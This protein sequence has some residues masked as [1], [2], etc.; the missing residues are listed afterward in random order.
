MLEILFVVSLGVFT[1]VLTGLTP[2]IH[3]NTV[4]FGTMPFYFI[5][6]FTFINYVSFVVGLS[7]AHTFHDFLPALFLGVPEG[8]SALA[9]SPGLQMTKEGKG[10]E[11]FH[12]TVLG[13]MW[14]V[15]LVVILLPVLYF[16]V[17]TAY[18]FLEP[19]MEY[20]LLFFLLAL[21]FDSDN[22][23]SS[24]LVA[25]LAGGLGVLSFS[26]AVNRQYILVPVFAGLFAFPTVFMS[27]REN[28]SIPVQDSPVVNRFESF[29][30]GFTG[31]LAGLVAGVFPGLGAA[32][33][34]SFLAPL[35]SGSK[36]IFLS[37]MGGVNTTDIIVSFL[38]ILLIGR[39][40][41]GAS[42]AVQ[43]V[44][45]VNPID[46]YFLMGVAL[47]ATGISIVVALNISKYYLRFLERFK[48]SNILYFVLVV[49][50]VITFYLTGF[51]GLLVL[52]VSSS[53]GLAAVLSSNRRV[54]MSVLLVPTI[55]F[56]A[57]IGILI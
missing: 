1:G 31:F 42:V 6:D 30:G 26:V 54:C 53:I 23:F 16:G 32:A 28:A 35:V 7:V 4:I 48:Y 2:G 15:L 56:F 44:S 47:F 50:I 8:E 18:S 41:S 3:P 40:R 34:T 9:V 57:D 55:L 38:A 29:K 45:Q 46:I 52:L 12:Y 11:A 43:S 20:F 22:W 21:I 13:G 37:S 33:A 49:L 17:E 27:L 25:C 39:A 5:F 24:F 14:S 51:L 36:R 19:N 10:L